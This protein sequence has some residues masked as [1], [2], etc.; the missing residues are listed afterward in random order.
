MGRGA[1][2]STRRNLRQG[3]GDSQIIQIHLSFHPQNF[4]Y[5]TD[6]QEIKINPTNKSTKKRK[7][8]TL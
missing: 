8:D 3:H 1:T 5:S 2:H 4:A 6:E 7:A